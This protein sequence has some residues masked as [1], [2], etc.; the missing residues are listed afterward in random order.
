[1]F[2][3]TVVHEFSFL[4]LE[5]SESHAVGARAEASSNFRAEV[6]VGGFLVWEGGHCGGEVDGLG[7][8]VG[9][10]K[11]RG[12][13]HYVRCR[14]IMSRETLGRSFGSWRVYMSLN[15]GVNINTLLD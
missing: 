15:F 1:L 14:G 9:R 2:M 5:A 8:T 11:R 4:A 7:A 12:G 13:Q 3:A 6:E 10:G